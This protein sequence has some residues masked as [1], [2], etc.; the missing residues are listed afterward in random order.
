MNTIYG[1]G[2]AQVDVEIKLEEAQLEEEIGRA[3]V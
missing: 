3:H 1:F 2:N